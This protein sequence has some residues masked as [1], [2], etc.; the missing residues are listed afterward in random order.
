LARLVAD[1]AGLALAVAVDRALAV[2]RRA[3]VLL[4]RGSSLTTALGGRS[5]DGGVA[6]ARV[7]TRRTARGARALADGVIRDRG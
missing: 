4:Q 3:L 7:R 1:D 6:G 5:L 2:V